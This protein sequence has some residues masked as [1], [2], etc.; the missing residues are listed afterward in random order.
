MRERPVVREQ[1]RAGRVGVEPA[2][3]DDAGLLRHELDDGRAALRVAR[4]RD[5]AGRLVQQ[6]VGEPLRLELPAVELDAV[7]APTNV[8]SCPGSPLTRHPAG[9]DQLVGASAGGDSGPGEVGVEA[10]GLTR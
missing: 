5:D 8:L 4:G 6:H 3:R 1:K 10:H 2:D 9:L 7:A